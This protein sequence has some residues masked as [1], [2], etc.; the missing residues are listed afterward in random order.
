MA[1][2]LRV[3]YDGAVYHVMSR[4]NRRQAIFKDDADRERFLRKVTNNMKIKL[5][6]LWTAALL[7]VSSVSTRAQGYLVPNGVTITGFGN[8][9]EI[10]VLQNPTNQDFTGFILFP[11]GGDSFSYSGLLDEG[12]RVFFVSPN[13]PVALGPML[14]QSYTELGVSA[15]SYNF[16]DGSSF[17]VGLYTGYTPSNGVYS[18]PMFGWAQLVSS[19]G[20]I[21]LLDSALAYQADGI[22]A[23]T[24]N[25]IQPVPEPSAPI[26]LGLGLLGMG[27]HCRRK[28]Q[29]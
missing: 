11:E 18:D 3:E 5:M 25:I 24:Q 12:V 19:G 16:V 23:G 9:Y 14:A 29:N 27:W 22:Y 10:K 20:V 6:V 2:K 1:R 13:D 4:G 26:L 28:L 21:E 8:G 7:V 17:Y 15:S